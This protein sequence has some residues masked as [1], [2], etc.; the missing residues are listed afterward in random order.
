MAKTALIT[1]AN[2]GIGFET[3]RAM[4]QRGV[5]I[6]MVCRNPLL[7]EVSRQKL[8][9]IASGPEPTL[10]IADLISQRQIR[11]L[12][13]TI[14]REHAALDVLVNNAGGVFAPR[15]IS[16]DGIEKTFAINHLAPFLLTNLLLDL[17]T[18]APGGRIVNVVT[19]VYPGRLDF[20][21]LQGEKRYNFFFAYMHS[22]LANIIFTNELARR[23]EDSRA[24]ANSISPG[25][26]VTKFGSA[27]LHGLPALMPRIMMRLPMFV[28]ADKSAR[29]VAR[30]ACSPELAGVSGRF[31]LRDRE[32]LGKPV[33]RERDVARRL[34][35][36]SEALTGL[37]D[38]RVNHN[39]QS[40]RVSD[41]A[42]TR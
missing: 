42:A 37:G 24:T 36:I 12:A 34:W 13:A 31:F 9:A 25:P 19:E 40:R 2:S 11:E 14:R 38:T 26:T 39:D 3:A 28:G 30:V 22:K 29:S 6:L 27:G 32:V 41:I 17:V 4:V 33:T 23:L 7:G 15:Q 1:G 5:Q 21:N 18:A 10:Y 35:D 16:E 20:E 8:A